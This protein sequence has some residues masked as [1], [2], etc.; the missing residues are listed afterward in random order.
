MSIPLEILKIKD[1]LRD[2][3]H[4]LCRIHI[5]N[6]EFR[7]LIDTGASSTVFDISKSHLLSTNDLLDN[8]QTIRTL[9]NEGMESKY[10][11][12][13]ELRIGDVIIKDYKTILVDL[14]QFNTVYKQH[15]QPLIDGIIGG[16]ILNNYNAIID[17]SKKELILT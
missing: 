6:K 10:L 5:K 12:I 3:Y 17:Y 8:E 15:L 7:M 11:I 14:K 2:G 16:D 13:D 4:I 9:G 1:S